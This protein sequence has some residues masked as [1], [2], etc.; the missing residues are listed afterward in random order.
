MRAF[1]VAEFA[2]TVR[3]WTGRDGAIALSHRRSATPSA[4]SSRCLG[5]EC[6]A[7]VSLF[8]RS[9]RAAKLLAPALVVASLTAVPAK[10][11][12]IYDLTFGGGGTGQLVLNLNSIAA[13]QNISYTS[14]A[15]YFVDLSANNVNGQNFVVTPGNLASGY[16]QTGALGQLYT[17]TVQEAPPTGVPTGT[18]YLDAYTN[19]WQ[20]HTTPYDSTA[21]SNSLTIGSPRLAADVPE[22]STLAVMF[23]G[24]GALGFLAYGKRR[25]SRRVA[26]A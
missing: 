15:P 5:K 25:G 3:L 23:A 26:Y 10:A 6:V 1:V 11:N 24:F 22:P 8:K 7:V 20:V 9:I 16:L 2:R 21:A 17:L 14:I 12:V 18:G 19:T 13:V 4:S